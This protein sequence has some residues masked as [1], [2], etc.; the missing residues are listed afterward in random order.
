MRSINGT[1][2]H[3]VVVGAGMVGL[4]TAW[5]LQEHGV[6][7]TVVDRAG[8]AGG[9]S[10]GNAGLLTPGLA[11]PLAE[12][13]ALRYGLS[14]LGRPDAALSVPLVPDMRTAGF[15]ARFAARCTTR[16]WRRGLADLGFLN[17]RALSAYDDLSAGGVEG[18][19]T[20]SSMF[21]G[22]ERDEQSTHLLTEIRAVAAAGV[23]VDAVRVESDRRPAQFTDAV[24][25]VWELRDQR[26]I[27]PEPFLT[28]LAASIR[29]R[30][31]EILDGVTV[32][33]VRHGSG[34]VFVDTYSTAPVRADAV[35][36]AT[37]AWITRF[38]KPLGV[39]V[40]VQ[41]GRGYSFSVE[42][43]QPA[44]APLYLPATRIACTPYQGRLR[45]AG[46]MEFRHPDAPM[47]PARIDAMIRAANP[48]L[49]VRDWSVQDAWVGS[50]PM[51]HDNLPLIGATRSPGVFVAGGHGMWGVLQGP[52]TGQLLAESIATGVTRPELAVFSPVR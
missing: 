7:V 37:G 27:E 39:R 43:D 46:T 33:D 16:A 29:A 8:V 42:T 44:T 17:T 35:V 9:S 6:R 50:R 45:V 11:A 10:W 24:T 41:A 49:R 18:A 26:F 38:A 32:R 47:N 5:F 52:V 19:Q 40:R 30:G 4:S 23:A 51:S 12:P 3:V 13:G 14:S 28:S 1:P 25:S 22:F 48:F 21:V 34:P 31:G 36:L 20:T 15:L 2:E